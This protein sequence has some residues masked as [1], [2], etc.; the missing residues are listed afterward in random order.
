MNALLK[1]TLIML[2]NKMPRWVDDAVR[3]FSKR[4]QEYSA[5]SL[6][7]IPLLRRGKTTDLTRILEKEMAEMR[8][9][10]PTGSR[11][12]ALDL[13]GETF[14]SEQLALK[15]ERIQHISS[16]LCLLIG[17]PE[18]LS[19][20]LLSQCDERWSLSKLTLPHTLA[21]ILILETLYRAFSIL[22]NHP[23]HK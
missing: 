11:L 16:H 6:I 15:L 7:A 19:P 17:G 5:F 9:A 21:R 20:A 10:I 2:G 14:S 12:I 1:I 22:N 23:Y 18:G 4:L 13:G 8:T 3:D